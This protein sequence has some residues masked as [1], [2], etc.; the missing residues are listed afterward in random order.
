MQKLKEEVIFPVYCKYP[1]NKAYFKINSFSEFEE[2][3]VM[4]SKLL[5]H[6]ISANILPDRN[7]IR[8]MVF[9]YN[10]YWRTND[11]EEYERL[12]EKCMKNMQQ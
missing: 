12:K 5:F 10:D 8:D 4:G 11:P 2:I 1:N 7:L 3:Q 9:N 6:L